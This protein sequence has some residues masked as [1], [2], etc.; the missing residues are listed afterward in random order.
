M[1]STLAKVNST[2][3]AGTPGGTGASLT[4][5]VAPKRGES[6][7]NLCERLARQ[8][9]HHAATPLQLLAFGRTDACVATLDTLKKIF[10]R[11]DW[12]VTWVAGAA[13][14]DG[15]VAGIQIHAFTGDV[16][17][18]TFGGRVV[19]SVFTDGGARQC[20]IGGLTPADH[21]LSRPEQ[22][23]RTL[24]DLQAI[25]TQAGFDFMDIVRTWF[26]L[27]HILTWYDDFNLARTKIYSGVKFRTGS[28]PASTGIGAQN[29]D[30]T[31]LALAAWAF[32]PLEKNAYAREIASPLQCPA[33]AY[34]SSFS[35]AMEI[36]TN[37]GRRLFIS[38][39]ASI[40]PGGKTLWI[41]DVHK[42]VDQTMLVVDE[43]LRARGFTLANLSRAT[44]YFRHAAGA[45]ALEKW[46]EAH[47][48]TQMPVVPAQCDI[49]RD[50]LLFE[51]EAEADSN[52]Q[53][54]S[55][56]L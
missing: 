6:L 56:I 44:A 31:A 41:G 40:A 10:G 13:C 2:P 47:P 29:P 35:R 24:E 28:M 22:T 9:H 4:F 14:D 43:I 23:R 33:P 34:G 30:G 38:G 27:D 11:L 26:Y 32:R 46:L 53:N 21:S 39:T 48:L 54:G 19:G 12:P 8:V 25:L 52:H 18:I 1:T 36:S 49:C 42:Q 3:V 37:A 5:S 15:P 7:F 55:E 45:V 20:V 51:L 50:N 16:E 17:R